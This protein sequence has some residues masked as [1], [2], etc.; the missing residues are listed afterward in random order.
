MSINFF[1]ILQMHQY[2]IDWKEEYRSS[3]KDV[4]KLFSITSNL[5]EV[6]Q[7]VT[8]L[9]APPAFWYIIIDF[10]I[11]T[12]GHEAPHKFIKQLEGTHVDS[13]FF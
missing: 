7:T 3:Y 1:V 13:S 2:K 9:P 11:F 12:L 6:K 8:S 5:A 4:E 10:A